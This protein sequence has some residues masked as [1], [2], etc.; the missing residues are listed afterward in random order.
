MDV[1]GSLYDPCKECGQP[2][3]FVVNDHIGERTCTKCGVVQEERMIQDSVTEYRIFS[4]EDNFKKRVGHPVSIF[5]MDP[6]DPQNLF[7]K[8]MRVAAKQV[9]YRYYY[10]DYIPKIAIQAT[11]G[12]IEQAFKIQKREKS[13]KNDHTRKKFSNRIIIVV[14]GCY[15]GL[16]QTF[17]SPDIDI[18]AQQASDI[19]SESIPHAFMPPD[20]IAVRT[21]LTSMN[22]NTHYTPQK[23]CAV[24]APRKS[25]KYR[26]LKR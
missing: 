8:E 9:L 11:Y 1:H 7:L 17:S 15:I 22:Y 3:S 14:A 23:S 19:L 10:H 25:R 6:D 21:F 2:D 16:R 20:A 4:E 18:L 5:E 24:V 13:V 26:L 12:V